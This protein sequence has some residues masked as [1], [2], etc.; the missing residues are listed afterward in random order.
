MMMNTHNGVMMKKSFYCDK[1][2]AQLQ[3]RVAEQERVYDS[4][5][6]RE[7]WTSLRCVRKEEID[8]KVYKVFS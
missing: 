5:E 2:K 6:K 1:R 3:G 7:F 8:G 4:E